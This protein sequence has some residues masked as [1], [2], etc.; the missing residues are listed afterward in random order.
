[1]IPSASRRFRKAFTE[2]I[3]FICSLFFIVPVWMVIVNSLKTKKE[4]AFFRIDFPHSWEF[5]NYAAVFEK[6]NIALAAGNGFF[7]AGVVGILSL[8]C[9]SMASFVISRQKNRLVTASYYVFLSGIIIPTAIIPTYFMMFKLD[10]IDT[11]SGII[12]LLL[13]HTLPISVFIYTGFM[14]SIP[15]EIDEA[16]IIDGCG[17]LRLFFG[18]IFPLLRPATITIAIFN[19]MGVWNDV[20]LQIYFTNADKWTMPMMVYRFTGM[21]GSDWNLVFTD[22]ILTAIPV[23]LVYIIFQRYMVSGLT[24]G[25]VKG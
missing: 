17:K 5:G 2:T 10:L 9:G 24:S 1:M 7:L 6:A 15:K 16:G 19:F 3:V 25:S 14:K 23:M 21:Y 12:A 20:M 8:L 13:A 18:I 11:Y 22:L 4:A